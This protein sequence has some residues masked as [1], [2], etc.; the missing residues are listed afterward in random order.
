M[1]KLEE[2]TRGAAVK[3]TL[4]D[5]LVT[6]IDVKRYCSAA[7]ELTYKDSAGKP[8]IVLLYRDRERI[9]GIGDSHRRLLVCPYTTSEVLA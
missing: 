9:M 8:S 3:G 5:C 4:P 1:S 6:V 7:I 2:L